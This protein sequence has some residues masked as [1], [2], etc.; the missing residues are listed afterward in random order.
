MA[1]LSPNFRLKIN[2][3]IAKDKQIKLNSSTI[4]ILQ[5]G[6]NIPI[7]FY[8]CLLIVRI[9]AHLT[10]CNKKQISVT[11]SVFFGCSSVKGKNTMNVFCQ[12]NY[13]TDLFRVKKVNF[14]DFDEILRLFC[15]LLS[16]ESGGLESGGKD[17]SSFLYH[18]P[19][20]F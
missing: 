14:S 19:Y 1:S 11:H 10:E 8:Q 17:L 3:N 4:L 12:K 6:I 7:R 2:K 9:T 5:S 18:I 13:C 16:C 15:L 20:F